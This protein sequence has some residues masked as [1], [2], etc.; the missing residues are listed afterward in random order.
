MKVTPPLLYP[1]L[2]DPAIEANPNDQIGKLLLSNKD[3][4]SISKK[5]LSR[6]AL[7]GKNH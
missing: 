6:A 5:K 7:L 1:P 2:S 3:S 4:G